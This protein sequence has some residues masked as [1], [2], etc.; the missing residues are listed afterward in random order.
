MTQDLN[1][2]V[3]LHVDDDPKVLGV[4]K[5]LLE[6][7][8]YTVV[9]CATIA[10]AEK[11]LSEGEF[12]AIIC[13]GTVSTRDDGYKLAT[14]L[15]SEGQNVI[16]FSGGTYPHGGDIRVVPKGNALEYLLQELEGFK[17]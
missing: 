13:D 3:V 10:E 15:H 6:L 11:A 14:R 7:L 12:H 5:D 16:V 9:S 17:S 8:G 1:K 4:I 2:P